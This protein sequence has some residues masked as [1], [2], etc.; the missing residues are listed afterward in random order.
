[1]M[2]YAILIRR[3]KPIVNYV[4]KIILKLKFK[5]LEFA[6]VKFPQGFHQKSTLYLDYF[7]FL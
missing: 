1:M 5:K 3:L 6:I 4:A 7:T 2:N